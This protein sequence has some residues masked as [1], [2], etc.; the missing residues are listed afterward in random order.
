MG[1]LRAAPRRHATDWP[2]CL[3]MATAASL[4]WAL[5]RR[6]RERPL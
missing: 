4:N 5:M 3:A 2:Q 6:M 1:G